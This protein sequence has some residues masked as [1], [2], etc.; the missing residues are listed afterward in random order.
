M[1]AKRLI[2]IRRSQYEARRDRHIAMC[3][4]LSRGCPFEVA[5]RIVSSGPAVTK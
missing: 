3:N 4:L 1:S 5:A 2:R